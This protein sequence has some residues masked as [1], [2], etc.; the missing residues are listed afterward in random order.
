MVKMI[1]TDLDGTLL[2]SDKTVSK[3]TMSI[4]RSCIN[5]GIKIALATAR[6]IRA[7]KMLNIPLSFDA[8]IYHNGAVINTDEGNFHY[9]ISSQVT[10]DIIL[11]ALQNDAQARLCIE[12]DDK[13]YGNSDPSDI[14]PGI[15]I[16]LTDFGNLPSA[17]ADKIILLT[18]DIDKLSAISKVLSENMYLE[19][20]ENTVG[21]I[22]HK[23]ATKSNAIK[24][25]TESFACSI[26]EVVAFGDDHNDVEMLRNCGMG[27]AVANAID[28]VKAAADCI[29]DTN[30]N[31]GVAKW[32]EENVL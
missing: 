19:I 15:E 20:S 9:G 14:W 7:V 28:K 12:I 13:I 10:K 18:A 31:D 21:M 11:A 25:L 17:P 16:N 26:D 27:V 30:D 3:Y 8:A 32:I 5:K 1:I 23:D 2:R 29:C 22:M 6:P 4:F 24:Q